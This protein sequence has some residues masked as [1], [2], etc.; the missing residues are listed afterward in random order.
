MRFNGSVIIA[1][2]SMI[3]LLLLSMSGLSSASGQQT[4]VL[5]FNGRIDDDGVPEPWELNL[6]D[7]EA[8]V[9]VLSRSAEKVV[10]LRCI[11]S[12]FSV[13]RDI[14]IDIKKY[15]NI[16]WRWKAIRLPIYGDLRNEDANDQGL[17]LLI[18]FEGRRIISYV[19]DS[20]APAGTVTDE[21]IGWPISLKIK[22]LVVKSGLSDLG[23]WITFS[24][25]I[26]N[27]FMMFF[28]EE[29]QRIKG[30]RIQSNTQYTNS[31]AEVLFGP[32]I[33]EKATHGPDK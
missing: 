7:G 18:A 23:K 11:N 6:K 17:Q 27:D 3:L 30:I 2:C 33:F 31:S 1:V 9:K 5:D 4:I 20:N 19:W 22:V 16:S 21:S 8:D 26:Y 32:I 24:R 13:E 10:R 15:Q 25:N 14:S 28:N 29:P 12:S